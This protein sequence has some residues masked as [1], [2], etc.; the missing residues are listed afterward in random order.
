MQFIGGV[1]PRNLKG[2]TRGFVNMGACYRSNLTAIIWKVE[3]GLHIPYVDGLRL[4]NLHI[5]SKDLP[6]WRAD[7]SV[8]AQ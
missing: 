3:H 2:D 6:R 7:R 4:N 5:H 8:Q 1:D